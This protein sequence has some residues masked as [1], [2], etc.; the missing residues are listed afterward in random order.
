MDRPL[1]EEEQIEQRKKFIRPN[2]DRN[3]SR[4]TI[5]YRM[6]ISWLVFV[7][8]LV[9]PKV[10]D[11]V[12]DKIS[13]SIQIDHSNAQVPNPETHQEPILQV[14]AARTW[15][16]KGIFAVHSWIAMKPQGAK[17]YE[18]SQVI[19]WRQR[20]SGTVLFRETNVPVNSWW[21]KEATLLL[22]LRG[23]DVT[24]LIKK[25]DAAIQAYPWKN[26]YGLY[27]GPNSNTFVAWIGLQDA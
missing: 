10:I 17:D 25:V 22:D 21:G 15:G 7:T 12:I 13:P 9:T 4:I 16:P 8:F 14:Y 26:E 24:P 19:G 5:S 27:P 11:Y 1:T 6:A 2:K 20:R 3:H 18:V 23:D